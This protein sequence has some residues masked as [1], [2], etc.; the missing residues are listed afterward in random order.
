MKAMLGPPVWPA[1]EEDM[2]MTV[3][4]FRRGSS[5]F[6]CNTCGRLTR[7]TVGTNVQSCE[8]CYELAGLQ[9]SLWDGCFDEGDIPARD[10]YLRVLVEKGIDAEKIKAEFKDLFSFQKAEEPKQE[11]VEPQSHETREQWLTALTDGLRPA[12]EEKGSPIPEKV[13]LS[14]GFTSHGSSGGRIGE[15]W[16]DKSSETNHVEIFIRPDQVEPMEVAA[17]V[18][19][20]LCHAALGNEAKHGPLFRKL[21]TALGLEGKMRSTTAGPAAVALLTP[22]V[23]GLGAYPHSA[24]KLSSPKKKSKSPPWKIVKCPECEFIACVPLDSLEE[25]WLVCPH[26]GEVLLTKEERGGE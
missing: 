21:A 15:C 24:L 18:L 2:E 16:S 14:C 1:D 5:T 8:Q 13:R 26:D 3:S 11:A 9:N 23:E 20:E 10:G 6:N 25:G 7:D 19:H 22:I 4:K 12:F 17:V